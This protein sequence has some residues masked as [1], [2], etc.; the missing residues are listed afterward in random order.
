MDSSQLKI[1][2]EAFQEEQLRPLTLKFEPEEVKAESEAEIS[3]ATV[4]GKVLEPKKEKDPGLAGCP[5]AHDPEAQVAALALV[6]EEDEED[7]EEPPA[8]QSCWF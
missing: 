1:E 3:L 8:S 2:V 4:R 7:P 6:L 5:L